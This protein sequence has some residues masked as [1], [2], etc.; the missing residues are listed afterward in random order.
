MGGAAGGKQFRPPESFHRLEHSRFASLRHPV[1]R[2]H[3]R[4]LNELTRGL[5]LKKFALI[6]SVCAVLLFA[7]FAQAQQSDVALGAGVLF[8]AKNTNA[9]LAYPPPAE[10]GGIY[11]SFSFDRIF[12]NRF[13]YSAELATSYKQQLYNGYQ[14]YRPFLYDVNAVFAPHL[15]KKTNADLMAGIGGQTLVF[16]SPSGRCNYPGGCPTHLNST[17]FVI[18]FGGGVSYSVWRHFFVRPEAHFYHI[19]NNTDFH[20]N[21]VLRLGASIGYTFG[22]E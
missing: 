14:G 5:Y 16:Y 13:G 8:S 4:S 1:W 15:A 2:A 6:P 21:N 12:A 19:V 22:S 17:H 7:T 9:S 20:S 3:P 11:P 18:H 10:K